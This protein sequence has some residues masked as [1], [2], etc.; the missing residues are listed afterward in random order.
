MTSLL[1]LLLSPIVLPIIVVVDCERTD[2]LRIN[3]RE[4]KEKKREKKNQRERVN[5]PHTTKARRQLLDGDDLLSVL[6]VFQLPCCYLLKCKW[7]L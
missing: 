5:G 3:K 7:L 2:Q 6:C 4:R 1:C